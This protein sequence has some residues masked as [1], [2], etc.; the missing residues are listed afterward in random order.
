[1]TAFA[2]TS[3]Q[4]DLAERVRDLAS[5]Q[6]RALAEAETALALQGLGS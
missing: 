4:Q 5:G 6:L 3:E 2:L 1:M